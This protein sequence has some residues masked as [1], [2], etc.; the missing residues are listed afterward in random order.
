V[1]CRDALS[2]ITAQITQA[3]P[4]RLTLLGLRAK[5][6]LEKRAYLDLFFIRLNQRQHQSALFV[7]CR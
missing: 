4:A 5:Q 3:A 6:F 7:C 1:L 2:A